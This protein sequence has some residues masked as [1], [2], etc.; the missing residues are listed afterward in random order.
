M[1]G[2]TWLR[3]GLASMTP[4]SPFR[5]FRDVRR[6]NDPDNIMRRIP[7]GLPTLISASSRLPVAKSGAAS[8]EALRR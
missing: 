1:T 7:G 5:D 3:A 2:P 4:A 6:D 8:G